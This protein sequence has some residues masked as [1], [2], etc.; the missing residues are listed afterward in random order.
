M[1]NTLTTTAWGL[2]DGNS[3]L[4]VKGRGAEVSKTGAGTYTIALSSGLQLDNDEM[5]ITLTISSTGAGSTIQLDSG[6]DSVKT[7]KTYNATGV[8]TDRSFYF[9]IEKLNVL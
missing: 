1:S 6:T 4:I 3:G 8:L 5:M 9:K 7:V 2:V